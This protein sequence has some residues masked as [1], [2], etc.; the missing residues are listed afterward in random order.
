MFLESL[1][2]TKFDV[3]AVAAWFSC[4]S[5]QQLEQNNLQIPTFPLF[6]PISIF[7]SGQMVIH[8]FGDSVR[9]K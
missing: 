6:F 3:Q 9:K 2:L 4:E 1:Y 7:S 8:A 5:P